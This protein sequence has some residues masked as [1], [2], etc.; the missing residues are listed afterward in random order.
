MTLTYLKAGRLKQWL[1][2]H[3]CP[4]FLKEFK[5]V[6]DRAFGKSKSSD[7]P[8]A[9]AFGPVPIN[10]EKLIQGPKVAC[11]ARHVI[12]DIVYS[13]CST[14]VG[15]SLIMFYPQGDG[16]ISA[17][18]G[19]IQEIVMYPNMDVA[20]IVKR[21]QPTTPGLDD[22]F[23]KYPHFP[24]KLYSCSLSPEL[25]IVRPDWVLSHYAR[26]AIDKVNAV[27]LLLSRVH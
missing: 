8:A 19:S 26:W 10:L 23:S 2:R 25:E 22:P 14:H 7:C 4:A 17:V 21:Q 27:V 13:R 18:P 9:S 5:T 16:S 3:D 12:N 15:N 11:R 6:F 24:A 1:A 20:Y